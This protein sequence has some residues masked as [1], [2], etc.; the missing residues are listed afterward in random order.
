MRTLLKLIVIA[1]LPILITSCDRVRGNKKVTIEQRSI[2][3]AEKLNV[4]GSM[5]VIITQ[6]DSPSL[7]VE[8]EE[9]LQQYIITE[10]RNN[11]LDIRFKNGTSVRAYKPIRIKVTLPLIT[12]IALNGSGSVISNNKFTGA[13]ATHLNVSGSG[14][15]RL[16]VNTPLVEADVTGSGDVFV[17]GETQQVNIH[18]SGSGDVNTEKL[19]AENAKVSLVGSG[20]IKVFAD[21]ELKADV[22]GSGDVRYKGNAAVNSNV[23]GSGS[24]RKIN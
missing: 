7:S 18:L 19:M 9:N 21:V 23:H 2:A 24:V 15:I 10:V 3:A 5:D 20:D 4:N 8:A 12:S 17:E 1:C 16:T 13:A 22:S 11:T 6:G 14:D